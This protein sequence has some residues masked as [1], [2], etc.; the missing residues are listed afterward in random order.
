MSQYKPTLEKGKYKVPTKTPINWEE[1]AWE[2]KWEVE[3]NIFQITERKHDVFT[4][5]SYCFDRNPIGEIMDSQSFYLS[6]YATSNGREA[7]AE[8]WKEHQ[9]SMG[10][11]VHRWDGIG[12]VDR[13]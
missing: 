3:E 6:T 4:L 5:M 1:K 2:R 9:E 10:Y 7:D 11:E 12:E 13:I 8:I